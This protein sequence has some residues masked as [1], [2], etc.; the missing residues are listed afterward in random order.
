MC[1]GRIYGNPHLVCFRGASSGCHISTSYSKYM[2]CSRALCSKAEI[3][4]NLR[5]PDD[6]ETAVEI[7]D[8]ATFEFEVCRSTL[9]PSALKTLGA[10]KDAPLPVKLFE[11]RCLVC[12]D[13]I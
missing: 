1:N 2:L 12:K 13:I 8:P 6:G 11:V 9:L 10:N 3:F 7:G 4:D 5:R